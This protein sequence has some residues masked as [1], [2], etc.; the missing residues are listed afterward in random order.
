VRR[1]WGAG[2][3]R[4]AVW[5]NDDKTGRLSSCRQCQPWSPGSGG[6]GRRHALGCWSC[7]GG[8]VL[9]SYGTI[10]AGAGSQSR[11]G[12]DGAGAGMDEFIVVARIYAAVG[13]RPRRPTTQTS[14]AS[15]RSQLAQTLLLAVHP[16]SQVTRGRTGDLDEPQP[17]DHILRESILAHVQSKRE[18]TSGRPAAGFAGGGATEHAQE[19][20]VCAAALGVH[21]KAILK[22]PDC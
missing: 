4:S 7:G 3:R 15:A 2:G 9:R 10:H 21:T 14:R 16:T 20:M 8:G 17:S 11:G 1:R 19:K 18:R 13:S 6:F 22:F 12:V 5:Y